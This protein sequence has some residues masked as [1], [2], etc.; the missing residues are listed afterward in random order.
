MR[1]MLAH[2]WGARYQTPPRRI[3]G[4]TTARYPSQKTRLGLQGSAEVT[5]SMTPS[6]KT[7]PA[8]QSYRNT[9][10]CGETPSRFIQEAVARVPFTAL[11]LL[12]CLFG[13]AALAQCNPLDHGE[14]LPSIFGAATRWPRPAPQ[15]FAARSSLLSG[16]GTASSEPCQ[17]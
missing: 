17:S 1:P 2:N 3:R 5:S 12:A 8:V 10:A 14:L 11:Y 15:D 7:W 16:A 9:R 13:L 6:E 4:A